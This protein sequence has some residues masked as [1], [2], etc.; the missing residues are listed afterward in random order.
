LSFDLDFSPN[1]DVRRSLS[2][3]ITDCIQRWQTQKR[4]SV[5]SNGLQLI[6]GYFLYVYYTFCLLV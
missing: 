2:A 6:L 5:Y 4:K 1:F 3:C